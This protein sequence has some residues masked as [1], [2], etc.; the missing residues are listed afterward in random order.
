MRNFQKGSFI[1][2]TG[3]VSIGTDESFCVRQYSCVET[4]IM[5]VIESAAPSRFR[6][7]FSWSERLIRHC[8]SNEI[9]SFQ[10][11]VDH[12]QIIFTKTFSDWSSLFLCAVFVRCMD[13]HRAMYDFMR[14]SYCPFV[15]VSF[16]YTYVQRCKVVSR[17]W[18]TAAKKSWARSC[19]I[20]CCC[21]RERGVCSFHDFDAS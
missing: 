18:I 1:Y 15:P 19:S 4:E 12:F 2:C 21:G 3:R 7:L 6:M 20:S 5:Q 13:T 8:S 17:A 11:L 10:L 16:C 14:Q 9:I